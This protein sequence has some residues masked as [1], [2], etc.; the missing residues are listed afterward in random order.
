MMLEKRKRLRHQAS[1]C[2]ALAIS[3]IRA[4]ARTVLLDMALDYEGRATN[5]HVGLAK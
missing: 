2:R 1:T 4:N 5:L 3:E